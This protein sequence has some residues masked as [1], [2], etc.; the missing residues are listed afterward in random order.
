MAEY[1]QC[2]DCQSLT[3]HADGCPRNHVTWMPDPP[4]PC[5]APP[6]APGDTRWR[7][8]D[9]VEPDLKWG[10]DPLVDK[11]SEPQGQIVG[12]EEM[13]LMNGTETFVAEDSSTAFV[14]LPRELWRTAGKCYCPHCR[15]KEGFWDALAIDLTHPKSTAWTV[16]FP[17]F[18]K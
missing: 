14:R 9:D 3:W 10:V 17:V 6:L 13:P 15:G 12:R 11:P 2:P 4:R 7:F 8:R 1:A 18:G 5:A 16:H